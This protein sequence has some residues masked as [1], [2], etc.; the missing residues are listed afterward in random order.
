MPDFN[1]IADVS[2][3]MVAVLNDA[4]QAVDPLGGVSAPIA[5]LHDLQT[6]PAPPNQESGVLAVTLVEN[7]R[8]ICEVG[9]APV[10]P[11]EFV[12]FRIQKFTADS[13]LG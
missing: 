8:L 12:I 4:L 2:E 9:I 10:F 5:V 11:A 1:V 13:K 3:T 7:G 6:P